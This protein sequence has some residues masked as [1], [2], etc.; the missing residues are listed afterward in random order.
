MGDFKLAYPHRMHE[1]NLG[2]DE[3]SPLMV[4]AGQ[5]EQESSDTSPSFYASIPTN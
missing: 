4:G 2:R 3:S 5:I 1:Q